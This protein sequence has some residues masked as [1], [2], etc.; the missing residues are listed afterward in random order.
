MAEAKDKNALVERLAAGTRLPA[1]KTTPAPAKEPVEKAPVS[2]RPTS[3]RTHAPESIPGQ[4]TEPGTEVTTTT[5][6][7]PVTEFYRVNGQEYT[8]EQLQEQGMLP[9]LVTTYDQ[10]QHLQGK[11]LENL[12]ELDTLKSTPAPAARQPSAEQ[13]WAI[14]KQQYAALVAHALK[15]DVDSGELEGDL[16]ELYPETLK[17]LYTRILY[18]DGRIEDARQAIVELQQSTKS[19]RQKEVKSQIEQEIGKELDKLAASDEVYGLLSDAGTRE[20]FF[21]Y[22]FDLNPSPEQVVGEK[23]QAFLSKQWFAYNAEAI[24]AGQEPNRGKIP[25][26]PTVQGEGPTSRPGSFQS[27]EA[28]HLDQ[29]ASSR[30]PLF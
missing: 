3:R 24:K 5:P 27:E 7:K 12:K 16:V 13:V 29:L 9:K 11:Y 28:S 15:R 2:T 14:V 30:L 26:S 6:S 18:Q 19:V 10:H 8:L 21:E 1:K 4:P 20:G 17:T 22:L 25:A 23:A